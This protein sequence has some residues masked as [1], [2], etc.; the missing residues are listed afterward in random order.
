MNRIEQKMKW[1][2]KAKKK[3][4]AVDKLALEVKNEIIAEFIE[5]GGEN[6][7]LLPKQV[8]KPEPESMV[9][10]RARWANK[11]TARQDKASGVQ[12]TRPVQKAQANMGDA[13]QKARSVV[14]G[15]AKYGNVGEAMQAAKGYKMTRMYLAEVFTGINGRSF[16][17]NIQALRQANYK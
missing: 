3:Q 16:K 7:F 12:T 6:V 8:R 17:A 4:A 10:K 1:E 2:A 15:L 11:I 14:I 9:Q 13:E 5:K